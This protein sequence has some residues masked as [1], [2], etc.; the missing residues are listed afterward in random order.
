MSDIEKL[1]KE[2]GISVN[3]AD[4]DLFSIN[5]DGKCINITPDCSSL[6]SDVWLDYEVVEND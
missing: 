4:G 1:L 6:G 3:Y 2:N 5:V